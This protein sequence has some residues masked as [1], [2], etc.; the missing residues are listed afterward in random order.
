M[1]QPSFA[2]ISASLPPSASGQAVVLGKL[3]QRLPA[4]RYCLLSTEWHTDLPATVRYHYLTSHNTALVA[5]EHSFAHSLS[6][7]QISALQPLYRGLRGIYRAGK[8][9]VYGV[10][11]S[12]AQRLIEQRAQQIYEIVQQEN[13]RLIVG[14]SGELYDLPAARRASQ[15][16]GVPFVAYIL[17]Y[18]GRGWAG[19]P[20]RVAQRLEP[21]IMRDAAAVI[22]TNEHMAA[23]YQREYGIA[24][25]IIRNPCVLPPPLSAGSG[26]SLLPA[27]A[28]N[29][30]YTGAIYSAHYDA[31]RRLITAIRALKRTDVK[32]HI[33]TNQV[34]SVLALE[35]ISPPDV[36]FHDYL[37][38]AEITHVQQQAD[39]LF[40]PLAFTSAL[41]EMIATSSPG[42]TGEYLAAGS[43]VLVHAPPDSFLSWYFRQHQCGAVVDQE[44]TDALTQTLARLVGDAAWRAQLGQAARAQAAADF[45]LEVVGP[46]FV[47]ALETAAGVRFG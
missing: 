18:Y 40:L 11:A 17:D 8:R 43:A 27:D 19:A 25:V 4:A 30:V 6:T 37:P 34:Q 36:T 13:C 33:F 46:C 28:I 38:A 2:V 15:L 20:G 9:L 14:C 32:L 16:A 12:N 3:L 42:K 47:E 26:A 39:I 24:P 22:V 29:I 10:F 44:D 1:T 31:F 23:I 5:V 35:G 7:R 41:P 21:E 45:D